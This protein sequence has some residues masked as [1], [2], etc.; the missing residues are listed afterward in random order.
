MRKNKTGGVTFPDFKHLQSY[1]N[2]NTMLLV[3]N[4]HTDKQNSMG[5]GFVFSRNGAG[6]TGYSHAK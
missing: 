3:K 6:K 5:K 4:I 1:N 2:Q